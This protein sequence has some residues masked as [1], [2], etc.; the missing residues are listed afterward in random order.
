MRHAPHIW[1]TLSN[2]HIQRNSRNRTWNWFHVLIFLDVFN[3]RNISRR[4]NLETN[5]FTSLPEVFT[6]MKSLFASNDG[7]QSVLNFIHFF[8]FSRQPCFK[9]CSKGPKVL[10]ERWHPVQGSHLNRNPFVWPISEALMH[11]EWCVM[12]KERTST[13][14]YGPMEPKG[15][16]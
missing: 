2:L 9:I 14:E 10:K 5:R 15:E 3:S 16:D 8:T 7:W 1:T 13:L 6:S 11:L 4:L 12:H